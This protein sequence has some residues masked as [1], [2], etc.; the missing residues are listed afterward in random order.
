MK[1]MCLVASY[2][3]SGS[4]YLAHEVGKLFPDFNVVHTH[5]LPDSGNLGY[6][7][8][9][10]LTGHTEGPFSKYF[11]LPRY[12]KIVLIYRKPSEAYLSRCCF[13]HFAHIWSNTAWFDTVIGDSAS[14]SNDEMESIFNEKWIEFRKERRDILNLRL[15]MQTWL[16]YAQNS[17]FDITFI[18]YENLNDTWNELSAY[19]S[20]SCVSATVNRAPFKAKTR[21]LPDEV[22]T[23]FALLDEE[24]ESRAPIEIYRQS[25]ESNRGLSCEAPKLSGEFTVSGLNAG[26]SDSI[27]RMG[28]VYDIV[29]QCLGLNFL[30]PEYKNYHSK[31]VDFLDLFGLS[32]NF[33]AYLPD[34]R[35]NVITIMFSDFLFELQYNPQSFRSDVVYIIGADLYENDPRL[36]AVWSYFQ[37]ESHFLK[38]LKY[39]ANE[40]RSLSKF[41]EKSYKA[42]FHLRRGDIIGEQLKEVGE[43][44]EADLKG[45]HERKLLTIEC[46][47]KI[48]SEYVVGIE[49]VEVVIISDGVE[50]QLMRFSSFQN[51]VSKLKKIECELI[52]P[53]P[54]QEAHRIVDRV[55]GKGPEVTIKCIDYMHQADLVITASSCFPNLI[56]SVGET[57]L[58]HAW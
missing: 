34:P 11:G 10:N 18:K 58:V 23:I 24:L 42:V 57:N 52:E 31:N 9:N 8:F 20:E 21:D 27:I 37:T 26:A 13:K 2:G 38:S 22:S 55:I 45:I 6:P 15:Y 35:K 12:S 48:L 40:C 43:Y 14:L 5:S 32:D 16:D 1:K 46:C 51:I 4:T 28:L 39:K 3:G 25:R 47:Y 17:E 50:D 56:C 30:L 49:N 53:N 41:S 7:V 33:E 54:E 44:R 36:R 19:L 29:T